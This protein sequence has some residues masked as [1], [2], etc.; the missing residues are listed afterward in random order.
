[1]ALITGDSR[2]AEIYNPV[3]NTSCSLLQSSERRSSHTQDGG[4][5]CGGGL[6]NITQTTC[7]KWSPASGTW[8][9]THTL[10]QA[11]YAHVSWAT[12][13]G[14]YLIGGYTSPSSKTSEKVKEDGSVEK[15]FDLKYDTSSAC[16]VPDQGNV[17]I[18]GGYPLTLKTASVYSEA[19]WQKDLASLNKGRRLSACGSYANGGEKFILVTG[20]ALGTGDLDS[21]EIFHNNVWRIVAGKLPVGMYGMSV[22]TINNRVLMF[23]AYSP[24]AYSKQILEFNFEKESWTEI[25]TMKEKRGYHSVSAVSYN[26]Y[27]KWCN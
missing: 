25:G 2:S 15:G 16:A 22:A 6:S 9:Q 19:G 4:L 23:G 11:R 8:T 14:V 27:S 21:T 7:V 26:D 13:S 20:G 10:R 5:L 24:S 18:I 17:I 1:V 12:S 3:T